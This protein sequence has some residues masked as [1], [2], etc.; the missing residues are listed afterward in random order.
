MKRI[1]VIRHRIEQKT[2]DR[3]K[4]R[5]RKRFLFRLVAKV[6][7]LQ[8]VKAIKETQTKEEE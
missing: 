4:A 6:D 1:K 8:V 5:Q 7:R 2:A 3:K